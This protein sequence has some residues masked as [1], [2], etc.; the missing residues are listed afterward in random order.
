MPKYTASLEDIMETIEEGFEPDKIL[1]IVLQLLD[2]L[3]LIHSK[4]YVHDN[5]KLS[6]IMIDFLFEPQ[7]KEN[8]EIE[9]PGVLSDEELKENT[10]HSEIL[11][12]TL[13]G[14]KFNCSDKKQHQRCD[15]LISLSLLMSI[16]LNDDSGFSPYEKS[17]YFNLANLTNI[18]TP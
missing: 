7:A 18:N 16:L 17:M 2:S 11:K 1:E 12:V 14:M 15:D 5:L 8:E 6:N 3:A 13:I 10:P 4:G 9:T